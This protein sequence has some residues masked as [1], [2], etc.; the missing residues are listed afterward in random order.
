M[1]VS[2]FVLVVVYV[3]F[4]RKCLCS[5]RTE[6]LVSVIALPQMNSS[7]SR[8]SLDDHLLTVEDGIDDDTI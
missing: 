4:K 8:L 7:L 2:F 1:F 5:C 3:S 6:K